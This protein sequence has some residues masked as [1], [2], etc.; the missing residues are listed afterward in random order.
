MINGC[1]PISFYIQKMTS[2]LKLIVIREIGQ[3]VLKYKKNA[4]KTSKN[5][6]KCKKVPKNVCG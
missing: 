2:Q 4:L 3:N 5:A 1:L 6:K